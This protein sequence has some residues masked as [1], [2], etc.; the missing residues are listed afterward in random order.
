[1]DKVLRNCEQILNLLQHNMKQAQQRMKRYSDWKRIERKFELGQQVYLRLQ[2]YRLSSVAYHS[3]LKLSPRFYGSFTIIRKVGEVVYE[4]DLP[5][6]ARIH[7][8]FH[9]SQL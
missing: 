1:V 6:D 5:P 9:M 4:L 8:I 7:P 3:T 2:S